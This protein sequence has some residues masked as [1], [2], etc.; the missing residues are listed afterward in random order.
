MD[1]KYTCWAFEDGETE[2]Q[3][4]EYSSFSWDPDEIATMYAEDY[5]MYAEENPRN[6]KVR[7][8]DYEGN[9]TD[10]LV[11]PDFVVEYYAREINV[12]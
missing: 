1:Y 4:K 12:K 8:K 10:W 3:G 5:W 6:L 7:V 2:E 11:E 9:V